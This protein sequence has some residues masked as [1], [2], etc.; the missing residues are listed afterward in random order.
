MVGQSVCW[1]LWSEL[2]PLPFF[3]SHTHTVCGGYWFQV[4]PSLYYILVSVHR[5]SFDKCCLLTF[6]VLLVFT[7]LHRN[8]QRSGL[9]VSAPG[10]QVI[11]L[12]SCSTQLS[13][14]FSLLI[15]MKMPF[16]YLLAEKFSCSAVFSKKEI[17]L[18]SNLRFI[19][20]TNFMLS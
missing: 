12:F 8:Y 5:F 11:K 1:S 20:R 13:L 6:L 19:S 18:L 15:N 4:C 2:F 17:V 3:P 14:K 9:V 16:S 7:K 10:P